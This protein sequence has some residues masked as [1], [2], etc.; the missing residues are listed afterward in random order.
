MDKIPFIY[1]DLRLNNE[2]WV[3]WFNIALT[4]R[5]NTCEVLKLNLLYFTYLFDFFQVSE[6]AVLFM[7][8]GM[9]QKVVMFLSNKQKE[10]DLGV[11]QKA[12]SGSSAAFFSSLTLCPTELIKCKQQAMQE[13]ISTGKLTNVPKH[14]MWV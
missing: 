12:V 2:L 1:S 8:Y 10:E 6:N 13:M 3:N 11:L 5:K 4:K 14:H 7:A 9:C